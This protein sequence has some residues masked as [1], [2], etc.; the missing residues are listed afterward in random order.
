MIWAG[1]G[2]GALVAALAA[3]WLVFSEGGP[4][5]KDAAAKNGAPPVTAGLEQR[6]SLPG[7]DMLLVPAGVFRF[8]QTGEETEMPAFYVDRTE[9]TNRAYA[10]FARAT[11]TALPPGFEAGRP[12]LP[13]V[14]VTFAEAQA[15]ADWAHKWLP[16]SKQWEKAARGLD[17]RKFPWG[18]AAESS[19]ANVGP[20]KTGTLAPAD[21]YA[22]GASPFQALQMVGNAWE[23]VD[24]TAAPSAEAMASFAEQITPPPAAG[25]R[26]V[27][28]RGGSFLEPLDT[29]VM[30][31][32]AIVPARYRSR[33]IGFRCVKPARG[34]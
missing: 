17:G 30:W 13:V 12:E 26:W 27:R 11:G 24:E 7:G 14:N 19:R 6:I 25:D 4:A 18:E 3:G 28:I 33:A 29:K 34:L 1:A 10:E 5:S 9:V 2:A 21:G 20:G 32:S 15:F 31:D 8:G 23:W 22:S 16:T